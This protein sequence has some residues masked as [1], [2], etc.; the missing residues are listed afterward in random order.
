MLNIFSL[1]KWAILKIVYGCNHKCVFCHEK[2][3]IYSFNFRNILLND[4]ENIL[5]WIKKNNFDYVIIS[6]WEPSL[7]PDFSK[8]IEFFQ[9]NNIYVVIVTNGTNILKHNYKNIDRNKI[10]F[11]ISY[12]WLKDNYNEITKSNDFEKVTNNILK[13]QKIFPEII[14]RYVVNNKN[15]QYFDDFNFFVNKTFKNIILEYVLVEDLKYNHVTN[16]I[17]KLKDFYK[18]VLKYIKNKNILLDWWL[19]C[20]NSYL[21]TNSQKKFDPLVNTMIWLVK[22]EKTWNLLYNIKKDI[23]NTNIKKKW[24]KCNQ[25]LQYK[26]C[27][28]VD[29]NYIKNI[30]KI[31]K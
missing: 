28:W 13:L 31:I 18:L 24:K 2:D 10:T 12:H 15:E 3:N 21:F 25:C 23:S 17:I 6:W 11:Y 5:L 29:V 8:I 19:A 4:L 27:H 30:S 16:C 22:K 20:I 1:K 14:L 7:H 9:K 26:Y